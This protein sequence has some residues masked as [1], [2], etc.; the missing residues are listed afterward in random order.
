MENKEQLIQEQKIIEKLLFLLGIFNIIGCVAVKF[1]N[2]EGMIIL[3]IVLGVIWFATLIL[4]YKLN[5][6]YYDIYLDDEQ[7]NIKQIKKRTQII[8]GIVYSVFIIIWMYICFK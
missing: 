4:F 5:Q 2:G 3:A 6:Y 1:V 7:K 8:I